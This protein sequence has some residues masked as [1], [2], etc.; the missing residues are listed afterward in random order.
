MN[1][2]TKKAQDNVTLDVLMSNLKQL[3]ETRA[4]AKAIVVKL[5]NELNLARIQYDAIILAINDETRN[6]NQLIQKTCGG[7][8]YDIP[9]G[10]EIDYGKVVQ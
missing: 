10:Q 3:H 4:F 6:I 5:G 2:P 8:I 1:I 9:S 7:V